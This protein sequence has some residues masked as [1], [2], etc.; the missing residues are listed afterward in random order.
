MKPRPG[1]ASAAL[2]LT[3]PTSTEGI[4]DSAEEPEWVKKRPLLSALLIR[5]YTHTD[6]HTH[7]DTDIH[8]PLKHTH[9]NRQS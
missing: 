3:S 8:T 6:T 4:V 9:E 7:T 1:D 5:A 2:F